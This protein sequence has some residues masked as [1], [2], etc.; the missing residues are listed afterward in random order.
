MRKAAR[1]AAPK[2]TPVARKV[3]QPAPAAAPVVAKKAK[4]K[5]VSAKKAN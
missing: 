4:A 3:E 2:T 5:K 1:A